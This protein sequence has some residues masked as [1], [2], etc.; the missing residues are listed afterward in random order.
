[1]VVIAK[2]NLLIDSVSVLLLSPILLF[3]PFILSETVLKVLFKQRVTQSADKF[4][5]MLTLK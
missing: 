4:K 3:E 5:A 1:M 2:S